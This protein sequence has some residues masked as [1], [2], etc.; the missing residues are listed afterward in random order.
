MIPTLRPLASF[1]CLDWLPVLVEI[2]KQRVALNKMD[3]LQEYRLPIIITVRMLIHNNER[4]LH[5]PIDLYRSKTNFGDGYAKD[6]YICTHI[7]IYTHLA[8]IHVMLTDLFR[9]FKDVQSP[10]QRWFSSLGRFIVL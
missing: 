2:A 1:R 7:N 9:A 6:L 8:C 3:D 5:V 10:F 4:T